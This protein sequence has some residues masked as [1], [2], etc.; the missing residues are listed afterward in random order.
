MSTT[1]KLNSRILWAFR[2]MDRFLRST[3]QNN[4]L[5]VKETTAITQKITFRVVSWLFGGGA[6]EGTVA[7]GG[8]VVLSSIMFLSVV[9]VMN[10]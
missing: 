4:E 5:E 1:A 7:V 9:H 8:H 10:L 3:L 2:S 6:V